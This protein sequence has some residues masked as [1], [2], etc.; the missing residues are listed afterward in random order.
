MRMNQSQRH[1]D[2]TKN[3]GVGGSSPSERATYS[4]TL[5]TPG[6]GSAKEESAELS[7]VE[8]LPPEPRAGKAAPHGVKNMARGLNLAPKA[9]C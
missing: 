9:I 5:L 7:S 4:T 6:V 1:I 8:D 3:R 2:A